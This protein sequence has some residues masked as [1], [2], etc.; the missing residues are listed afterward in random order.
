MTAYE[1][2][3]SKSK[4]EQE[5]ETNERS[6]SQRTSEASLVATCLNAMGSVVYW[7]PPWVELNAGQSMIPGAIISLLPSLASSTMHPSLLTPIEQVSPFSRSDLDCC[8]L[9]L[10]DRLPRHCPTASGLP[11]CYQ[12]FHHLSAARPGGRIREAQLC[13]SLDG[14]RVVPGGSYPRL[15]LDTGPEHLGR[16]CPRRPKGN[17]RRR[18]PFPALYHRFDE[19]ASR[20]ALRVEC[21]SFLCYVAF[22]I[23]VCYHTLYARPWIYAPLALYGLDLLMRMV[24]V[25]IQDAVLVPAD[26]QMTLV[27][28]ECLYDI[29]MGCWPTCPPSCLLPRPII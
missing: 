21:I 11:L 5:L 14:P 18:M 23:T 2:I 16:G 4:N 22:F 19:F 7:S 13:P 12:K 8:L 9:T 1:R 6:H 3:A 15:S 26:K 27:S 28:F 29:R 20:E 10:P 17:D 25:R 24:K